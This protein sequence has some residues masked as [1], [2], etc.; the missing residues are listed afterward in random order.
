MLAQKIRQ[1]FIQDKTPICEIFQFKMML[2]ACLQLS[3]NYKPFNESR[4][5]ERK[6]M[7]CDLRTNDMRH[8]F[9]HYNRHI[10]FYDF[11]RDVFDS[12]ERIDIN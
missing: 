6:E 3:K 10:D 12:R 1:L 2:T 5:F 9:E 4:V 8:A 7:H 11:F